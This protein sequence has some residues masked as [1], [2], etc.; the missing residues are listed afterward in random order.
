MAAEIQR[1]KEKFPGIQPFRKD[2]ITWDA[3][4]NQFEMLCDIKGLG[5]TGKKH[6]LA[7]AARR[8]LLL[9]YVGGVH[10]EAATNR[11]FFSRCTTNEDLRRRKGSIP[12]HV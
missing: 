4:L 8:D 5:G 12:G 1:K 2:E 7:T 9:A 10:L 6:P 3:W 11:F